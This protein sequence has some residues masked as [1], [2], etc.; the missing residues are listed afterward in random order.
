MK[1]Q[2]VILTVLFSFFVLVVSAQN[3][4]GGRPLS[5]DIQKVLNRHSPD[6]EQL[7]QVASVGYPL[8][9]VSKKAQVILR[10]DYRATLP[11]NLV[12][13]GYPYRIISKG[14][15]RRTEPVKPAPVK[16]FYKDIIVSL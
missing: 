14:V 15:H 8:W 16:P 11:G 1:I 12:S 7:L 3:E 5:K 6:N 4:K 9:T 2:H 10:D 13:I